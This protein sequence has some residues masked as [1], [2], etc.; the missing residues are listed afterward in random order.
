M[1]RPAARTR[2]AVRFADCTLLASATLG[3]LASDA[4]K[5][6][7]TT[8]GP[9]AVAGVLRITSLNAK[10]ACLCTSVCARE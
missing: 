3:L 2:A 4:M 8:A 5:M 1:L 7:S 9:V 10:A 6:A